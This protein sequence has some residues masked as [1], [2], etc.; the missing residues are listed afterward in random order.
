MLIHPPYITSQAINKFC[1]V[2]DASGKVP[3]LKN[4]FYEDYRIGN[5]EWVLLELI[6]EVLEVWTVPAFGVLSPS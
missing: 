5:Q 4:K 1:V 3:K 2:A 6:C